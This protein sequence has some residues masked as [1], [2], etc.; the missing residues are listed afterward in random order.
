V[1]RGKIAGIVIG[2]VAG[3]AL[4]LYLIGYL[5]TGDRV[6]RDVTVA[7]VEIGGM[8]REDA[9]AE[10]AA[11][12]DPKATDPI[13]LSV[14]GDQDALDPA[15]AG[16]SVDY[17][18]TVESAGIGKS[19]DPRRMWQVLTGGRPVEP[20]ITTDRAT[21][22]TAVAEL[23]EEYDSKPRSAKVKLDGTEIISKKMKTGLR[24]DRSGTEQ[25]LPT[26]LLADQP[27]TVPV[28]K[29][30]PEITDGET[31]KL[32]TER[33][34]P[35]LS[36]PI[37]VTAG[38][39]GT[40]EIS[41][42][43]IAEAI[44]INN[45]DGKVTAAVHHKTLHRAA[46][47]AIEELD[48]TEPEDADV[49]ISDG[50]PKIIPGRPGQTVSAANLGKAVDSVLTEQGSERTA[51]V[52]LSDAEPDLSTDDAEKLGITE[53]TGEFT[54]RFPYAEYRNTNIGRAAELINGTL[55]EPGE[56]FSLN[57]VV[58]ERT[59][60]N[61]FVAGSIITGGKFKEELGGGVSQSATTTYNAMFFAGL[62]D[63]EHQPHTLYI[64]R[65]PA[66]REATVAWPS[67]DLKFRN[68]TKYGVLVQ[69]VFKESTPD[70]QGS[71]T[72]KM[73]STKTYDKIEATEPERTNFTD[74]QDISD[75]SPDCVPT[76]PVQGF[77]V[78]YSRLFYRDGKVVKKEDFEWT[79]AP[80]DNR[81]CG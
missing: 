30:R 42:A 73:W 80:T 75:N 43:M 45:D 46:E 77:D 14:N 8:T 53:V 40:V 3:L 15:V 2:A 56:T 33:L 81:M 34:E 54:T 38:D 62:E 37:T 48:I 13:Q 55:L 23:S 60:E 21:L 24:I 52:K 44:K 22:K 20:V 63:I 18:A 69:T 39:A 6:P 58:G 67:L 10:L 12:L 4:V 78:S 47:P 49:E 70:S 25:V 71:L 26:G 29:L 32:I 50:K 35:A 1:S 11:K 59:A 57:R 16:L 76:S 72:V 74:G 27:V 79:Y 17:Q 41:P 64:D 7:G 65:Y 61:G 9:I 28:Q 68:N 5:A 66:G 31:E 36:G 19:F 51:D